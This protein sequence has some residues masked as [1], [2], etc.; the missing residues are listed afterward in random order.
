MPV[1]AVRAMYALLTTRVMLR[2]NNSARQA[3]AQT[4]DR[5]VRC[6]APVGPQTP[7]AMTRTKAQTSHMSRIV[8]Q[9]HAQLESL[10][11]ARKP[12]KAIA[13]KGSCPV[14]ITETSQVLNRSAENSCVM[15]RQVLEERNSRRDKTPLPFRRTSTYHPRDTPEPRIGTS[16]GLTRVQRRMFEPSDSHRRHKPLQPTA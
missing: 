6:R 12:F 2:E 15:Q 7:V 9:S 3:Q 16:T 11:G 1:H 10:R 8:L 14:R 13:K 5:A 4:T